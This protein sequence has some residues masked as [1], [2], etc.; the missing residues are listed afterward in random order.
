[1]CRAPSPY[2]SFTLLSQLL[3]LLLVS[4]GKA[5][6]AIAR[7]LTAIPMCVILREFMLCSL[8]LLLADTSD[9][10]PPPLPLP[11]LLLCNMCAIHTPITVT[12]DT[13]AGGQRRSTLLKRF[14]NGH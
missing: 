6:V 4:P 7:R 9:T 14:V 11:S 3:L 8:T 5:T 1:M 2:S 12:M 10:P 13:A